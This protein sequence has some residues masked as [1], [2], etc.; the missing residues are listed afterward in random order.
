VPGGMCTNDVIGHVAVTSLA[1]GGFGA[2]GMGSY[3][4]RPGIDTFSHRRSTAVVPTAEEFEG[5]LVCEWGLRGE[6]QDLQGQFGGQI[7]RIG[8]KWSKWL[9]KAILDLIAGILVRYL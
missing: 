5:L 9:S 1:F 8:R 6:V 4:G 2:S 7:G 3:R